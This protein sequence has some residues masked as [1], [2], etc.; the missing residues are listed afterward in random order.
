MTIWCSFD[1]AGRYWVRLK[2]YKNSKNPRSK[3]QISVSEF[4]IQATQVSQGMDPCTGSP[5]LLN[6]ASSEV[7]HIGYG[8]FAF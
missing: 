7:G 4:E 2:E 3:C 8:V 1:V 5:P 6:Q